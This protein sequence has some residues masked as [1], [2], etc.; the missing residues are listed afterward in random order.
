MKK[1]FGSS[2]EITLGAKPHKVEGTVTPK[3]DVSIDISQKG[4]FHQNIND[5]SEESFDFG[6]GI[7]RSF[8]V[9]SIIDSPFQMFNYSV[10]EV[11]TLIDSIKMRG[12][13][14][15]MYFKKHPEQADKFY[16]IFGGHRFV[17]ALRELKQ[18]KFWSI[19]FT[20]HLSERQELDMIIAE[21]F[22]RNA[23]NIIATYHQYKKVIEMEEGISYKQIADRYNTSKGAVGNVMKLDK[24]PADLLEEVSVHFSKIGSGKLTILGQLVVDDKNE[25]RQA[26][27]E[28]LKKILK[29]LISSEIAITDKQIRDAVKKAKEMVTPALADNY[30]INNE[31]AKVI[32]QEFTQKLGTGVELK[33]NQQGGGQFKLK[34]SDSAS[35]ERVLSLLNNARN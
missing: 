8:T 22:N 31:D 4:S 9:D 16:P 23:P 28:E 29:M 11:S 18:E 24:W 5:K 33:F 26:Y 17:K 7:F 25:L 2:K 10:A 14:R 35:Y 21:N 34:F 12:N 30:L 19:E 13:K 15:I 20:E 6:S 3:I 32:Q 1:A 27:L